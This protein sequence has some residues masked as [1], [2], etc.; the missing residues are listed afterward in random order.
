MDN[1]YKIIIQGGITEIS[2]TRKPTYTET[3][4]IID[5]LSEKYPYELRLWDLTGINF[6]FNW[7]SR[8]LF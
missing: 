2:F 7:S 5:E 8:R 6:N 3:E 4:K 1:F